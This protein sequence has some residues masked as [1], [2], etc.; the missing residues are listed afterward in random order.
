M[1][2]AQA[3]TRLPDLTTVLEADG[4]LHWG[5]NVDRVVLLYALLLLA[6]GGKVPAAGGEQVV[7]DQPCACLDVSAGLSLLYILPQSCSNGAAPD[8]R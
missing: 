7:G 8:Q 2:G 6:A 4:Y 3:H 5:A 1:V